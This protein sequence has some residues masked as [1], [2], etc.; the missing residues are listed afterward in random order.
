[1][2]ALDKAISTSKNELE[3]ISNDSRRL[4]NEANMIQSEPTDADLDRLE[5]IYYSYCVKVQKWNNDFIEYY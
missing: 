4:Q 2:D 1:M 5:E 3:K